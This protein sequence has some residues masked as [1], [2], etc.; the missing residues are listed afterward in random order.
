PTLGNVV[1]SFKSALT[2]WAHQN[3]YP[4]FKWQAKYYDHIIRNE[5]DLYRIRTYIHYNPLKWEAD[6][7][8]RHN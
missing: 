7:Y 4:A 6:E 1:G 3:G 8:Y 5:M 2:K